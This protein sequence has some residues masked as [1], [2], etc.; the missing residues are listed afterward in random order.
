MNPIPVRHAPTSFAIHSPRQN[1]L[2]G[3]FALGCGGGLMLPRMAVTVGGFSLTLS[4]LPVVDG[5]AVT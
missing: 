4:S 1:L 3:G 5:L 2:V